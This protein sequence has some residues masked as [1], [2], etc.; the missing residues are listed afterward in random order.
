MPDIYGMDKIELLK[1]LKEQNAKM[2]SEQKNLEQ[3]EF[4][5]KNKTPDVVSSGIRDVNKVIW[6]FTFSTGFLETSS[7]ITFAEKNITITQEA[8]FVVTQMIKQ[9]FK[10]IGPNNYEWVDPR[11]ISQRVEDLYFTL[12][13]PQS[14]RNFHREPM[15]VEH[16]GDSLFPTKMLSR[17][18]I[19]PNSSLNV[20]L[21]NQS[22]SLNYFTNISLIGY[23]VR[24]E[25]AQELL[26]LVT[27]DF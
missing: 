22:A 5:L 11:D 10:K 17:P 7:S 18:L 24:I 19:L 15:L 12:S 25:D 21:Y 16:I 13:D 20:K 8:A 27:R 1:Y 23:R 3:L 14:G 2:E 9:V 4:S 6:P 26:G